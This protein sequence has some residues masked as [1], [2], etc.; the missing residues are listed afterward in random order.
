MDDYKE[1][2]DKIKFKIAMSEIDDENSKTIS[3]KHYIINKIAIAACFLLL[4]TGVTFADEISEKVYDIYNIRKIY[5]IELKLPEE[6]VDNEEK[7]KEVLNNKNSIM[8]WDEKAAD[9]V[10]ANNLEVNIT[11]VDMDYYYMYF[12][13]NI[14]FTEE[15]TNKMPLQDIY[16]VR[17]PD[18]VIRDENDNILFCMEEN[19]LKEIFKTDDLQAIKNNPKY[20]ISEITHYSFEDYEKLGTNPYK[21][22]YYLN[23]ILPSIYPKSKKLIFEFTKI[24]L[25]APKAAYGIDSK[26][27]LHQDQTLTVIGNWKIEIDVPSKYYNREDVIA[28]KIKETDSNPNNELLYCYYK[29]DVMYTDFRLESKDIS[30]PWGSAKLGDMLTELQIDPI[31]KNYV[32]Y[33]IVSSDEFK[34]KE[35]EREKLHIVEDYYIEN[36]E[37]KKSKENGLFKREGNKL[38]LASKT[39]GIGNGISNGILKSSVLPGFDDNGNWKAPNKTIFDISKDK[40][41]DEM[42]IH[43][44]YL[45][46]DINFKVEKMKGD[47]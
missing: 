34:K 28:Y 33:K 16:L 44:K 6:V 5:N 26:P 20:C 7:L 43:L 45:G 25:D 42:T 32:T 14:N 29:D 10:Q 41:T 46:K 3:K 40:L 12:E 9:T 24:A 2:K 36:S 8:K 23:T 11:R 31:I 38:V 35:A 39:T 22:Q 47:N 17:F 4:I 1:L 37:G 27:Y 13:A 30:G 21:L 18:L 15:V 19:K